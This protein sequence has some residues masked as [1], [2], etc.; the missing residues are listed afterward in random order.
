MAKR[1]VLHGYQIIGH[2]KGAPRSRVFGLGFI[3]STDA[4]TALS[5][6][7]KRVARKQGRDVTVTKVIRLAD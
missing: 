6:A 3:R 5:D 2:I 7:R 1:R 4:K